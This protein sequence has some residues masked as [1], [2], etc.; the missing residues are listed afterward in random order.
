M[1]FATDRLDLTMRIGPQVRFGKFIT[2]PEASSDAAMM[3]TKW[4]E[5]TVTYRQAYA[6]LVDTQAKAN[7]PRAPESRDGMDRG[8]GDPR[9]SSGRSMFNQWRRLMRWRL[10]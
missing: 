8:L 6:E 10:P 4:M 9:E 2:P 1:C 7:A 3:T 5:Q